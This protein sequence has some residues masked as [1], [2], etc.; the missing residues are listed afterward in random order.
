MNRIVEGSGIVTS[1]DVLSEQRNRHILLKD[2]VTPYQ[3]F[4]RMLGIIGEPVAP[5]S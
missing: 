1:S 2:D 3:T 4:G 5:P